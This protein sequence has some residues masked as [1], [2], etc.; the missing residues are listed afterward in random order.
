MSKEKSSGEEYIE[1]NIENNTSTIDI[2]N[3]DHNKNIE[4][5]NETIT[6]DKMD[7]NDDEEECS[8]SDWSDDEFNPQIS[9]KEWRPIL[10]QELLDNTSSYNIST[11]KSYRYGTTEVYGEALP[12]LVRFL[13]G[14]LRLRKEDIFCD[15]GSGIGNVI[16][17]VSAQAGCKCYGIE[18]REDLHIIAN[19]VLPRFK[20]IMQ[21][22]KM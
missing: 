15:I 11:L 12:N 1:W 5:F 22:K 7:I 17:Q 2:I 4:N 8:D 20:D 10:Y 9:L 6:N 13:I 19:E 21:N 14:K 3:I 18:I 16:F